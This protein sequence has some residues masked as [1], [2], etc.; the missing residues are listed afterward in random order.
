MTP[1]Q[2]L[3]TSIA[4]SNIWRRAHIKTAL[5]YRR[6]GN[7]EGKKLALLAALLEKMNSR[8]LLGPAPF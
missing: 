6:A 5:E 7:R 2:P 1:N 4:I 3:S 8:E